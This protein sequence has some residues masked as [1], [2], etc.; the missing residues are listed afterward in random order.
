METRNFK[1]LVASIIVGIVIFW[2]LV[3]SFVSL[4]VDP[5]ENIRDLFGEEEEVVLTIKGEVSEELEL[6]LSDLKSDQ[7][8]QVENQQFEFK[9]S[10]GRSFNKTYN[11]VSLWSILERSGI[12]TSSSETFTFVAS[13]GY[14]SEKPLDL[15][16]AEEYEDYVIIAYGGEDFNENEDGTLRSVIDR[17]VIPNETNTRFW[18]K[19]LTNILIE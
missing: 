1:I 7:Y 9:N 13:D 10:F 6:T 5:L 12:S 3:Y 14:H 16:L 19:Y 4:G 11:G 17:R 8:T 2:F 18:V 15:S